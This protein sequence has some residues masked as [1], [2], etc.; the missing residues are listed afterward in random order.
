[1]T[2]GKVIVVGGSVGGLFAAALLQRAGWQIALYERSV[3]GLG[4][5]GAG[6]VAQPD[7]SRILNEIGR[8][9]QAGS[10]PEALARYEKLRRVE[11]HEITQYGRQL[12]ASFG[13]E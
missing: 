6:L 1:V 12:G 11:G 9:A 13:G 2:A 8:E 3:L 10:I 5:K 7:V 4:G